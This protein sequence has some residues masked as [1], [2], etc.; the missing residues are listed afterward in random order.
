MAA[1]KK[2]TKA[3]VEWV[4]GIIPLPA[5]V[6]GEGEPYQPEVILWVSEDGLVLGS[7][8]AK[9]GELLRTA[10]A[11]L[12]STSKRPMIGPAHRPARVRVA[13]PELADALRAGHP[14]IDIVC[15]PTPEVD[16]ILALMLEKFTE[17]MRAEETYLSD[18]VGPEAVASFFRAAAGLFRAKPWKIV[19]DDQSLF[20]VT[21]ER[22]GVREAALSI[23]GQLG[24]SL[25]LILF[26]GIDDFEA[27]LDAAEALDDE[28]MANLPPHF[29]LNFER[30]SDLA[31]PLL[32]EIAEHRWEIAGA[33]AYPWLVAVDQGMVKRLVSAEEMTIAE[34]I[35]IA[36]PMMLAEKKAL[37]AAWN[38]GRPI[39]RTFTV[40]THAGE[41]E[42][43]LH[44]PYESDSP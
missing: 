18:E 28:A 30:R 40:R 15:A 7:E 35:A 9:P 31:P 21:I 12:E 36:L 43:T 20:S 1:K 5:T 3:G 44:A 23:I 37:L 38:G 11:H 2:T 24:E 33:A 10:S 32:D 6:T 25:G 29:A 22:F 27:Y 4:G 17:E 41:V 34:A 42:V 26:S 8:T 39:S 14:S 16:A 19:P 13:S